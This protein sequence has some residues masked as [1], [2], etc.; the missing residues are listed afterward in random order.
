MDIELK[1]R[2][3]LAKDVAIKAGKFAKSIRDNNNFTVSEKSQNDFVTTADKETE[4]YIY[5]RIK[6]A[7]PND[8]FLGEESSE[9]VGNGRWVV[10][11]IDGTTNYFRN[12]SNWAI[13]IAYEREIGKPLIGVIYSPVFDDIYYS[14]KNGG[15]F[16][17]GKKIEVSTISDFKYSIN[18]CV[19]PHRYKDSYNAYM[20]KYNLIGKSSSDLRSYGSCALEL[21]YIAEGSLDGYYELFLGY[22]DFAAGKI[23]LEE[24]GG[25]F[26]YENSSIEDKYNLIASNNNLFDWYEENIIKDTFNEKL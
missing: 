20:E 2:L 17:N 23:I 1:Q 8:G 3:D 11:P 4:E 10:D 16:K 18:V 5:S 21:C 14:I 13:S 6:E 9:I 15:S 25:K 24:A 22:Y 26:L 12:L 7:F 19:P